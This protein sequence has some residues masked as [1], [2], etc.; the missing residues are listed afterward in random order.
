MRATRLVPL[1]ILVALLGTGC[2]DDSTGP[3]AGVMVDASRVDASADAGEADGGAEEPD[4][5]VDGGRQDAGTD[6]GGPCATCDPVASCDETVTP[7]VCICP[8]GY[9]DTRGDGSEC[10]D[11]DECAD[12]TDDCDPVASCTNSPGSFACECP[13]G[14]FDRDGDGTLCEPLAVYAASPFQPLLFQNETATLTNVGCLPVTMADF[15]VQGVNAM[16]RHPVSGVVYAVVRAMGERR[17]ATLDLA[18][19]VATDIGALGA[20]FSSIAFTPDGAT[21]YGVTG[22]GAT[23]PET[24]FTIDPATGTPTL[25]QA[26]GNGADGEVIAFDDAGTL[27]HWSGNSTVVTE[28]I[29]IGV[30]VTDLPFPVSG[31]TF[32]AV[33]WGWHTDAAGAPD[34]VML[35]ST[36][37][38]DFRTFSPTAGY[39]GSLGSLPDDGRG[40]VFAQPHG[41]SPD[42]CP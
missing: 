23:P 6:G 42:D 8:S 14:T 32:G 4:A 11:I 35:I 9:A 21:L 37:N 3:D 31:E 33:W 25:V 30:G 12:G 39:S 10:T 36:I 2:D 16:T 40:L 26:L 1:G 18:T 20:N 15:T 27:Y 5:G 28:T 22:D 17:L 38:S 29:Q 41:Y 19:G 7:A 34:P 24:L 13:E